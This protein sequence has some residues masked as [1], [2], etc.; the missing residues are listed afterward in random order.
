MI[1]AVG[2]AK[3][4]LY[5]SPNRFL[6]QHGRVIGIEVEYAQPPKTIRGTVSYRHGR[7]GHPRV[8]TDRYAAT[9]LSKPRQ[10]NDYHQNKN[11]SQWD[12]ASRRQVATTREQ[13]DP[14]SLHSKV[15]FQRQEYRRDRAAEL[16]LVYT[17]RATDV[18]WSHPMG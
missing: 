2:R 18:H 8:M 4:R 15:I 17:L 3:F 16:Q 1:Q 12:Q 6:D 13:Q 9:A 5:P 10:D 11:K 14:G 7:G